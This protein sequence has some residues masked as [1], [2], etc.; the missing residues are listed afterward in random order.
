VPT[1]T[2]S[3]PD[4]DPRI[5]LVRE[6]VDFWNRT[7]S[8]IGSPFRLGPVTHTTDVV[9]ADF[10]IKAS[11]ATLAGGATLNG[12]DILTKM[13]GDIIIAT[14]DVDFVS[15]GGVRMTGG[16]ILVGIKSHKL[17]PL[18]L[19]NVLRNVIIHEIGHAIGLGHNNDPTRLMCGRPALCR[20]DDWQ[21]DIAKVFP[22]TEQ[23]KA[24]LLKI[25]PATWKPTR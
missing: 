20:P 9:P 17:L 12:P 19:P 6:A 23:E 15:F 5:A 4:N 24:Y 25:Y 10:L 1:I 21:S 8:E 22:L 18:S 16:R 13:P 2:V 11:E 3:A 14:S 7:L